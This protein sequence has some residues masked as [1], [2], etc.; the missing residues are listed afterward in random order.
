MRFVNDVDL[1]ILFLLFLLLFLF[2][3]RARSG[4]ANTKN[5]TKDKANQRNDK[6][7]VEIEADHFV[8]PKKPGL[9]RNSQ[10]HDCKATAAIHYFDHHADSAYRLLL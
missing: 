3:T 5:E 6:N 9:Q 10:L 4:N 8:P 7:E 2:P 1:P